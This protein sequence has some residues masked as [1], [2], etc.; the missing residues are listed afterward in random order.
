VSSLALATPVDNNPA[1][2]AAATRHFTLLI[3]LAIGCGDC[4]LSMEFIKTLLVI[5][6]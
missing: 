5:I 2:N 3:D 1:L 4:F 6:V